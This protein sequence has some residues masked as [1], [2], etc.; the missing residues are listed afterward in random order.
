L[1]GMSGGPP[2]GIQTPNCLALFQVVVSKRDQ[3]PHTRIPARASVR[4]RAGSWCQR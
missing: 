2:T 3:S 4:N 1:T